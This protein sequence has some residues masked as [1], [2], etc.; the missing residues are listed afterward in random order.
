L[1]TSVGLLFDL[2]GVIID[3]VDSHYLNYVEILKAHG[4]V[5]SKDEFSILNGKNLNEIV[6][7][8]ASTHNLQD[9][10]N[11]IRSDFESKFKLSLGES[12]LIPGI[13]E[14][15]DF[16]KTSK[17]SLGVVS[18]SSKK[19]IDE[20]LK[21]H[22]ISHYFETIVSG[23]EVEQAKPN[24]AIYLLAKKRLNANLTF[25]VEDTSNGVISANQAGIVTI[26]YSPQATSNTIK[27]AFTISRIIN[28][29]EIVKSIGKKAFWIAYSPSIEVNLIDTSP[30]IMEGDNVSDAD[31][32][33][34]WNAEV[35]KNSNL[36]NEMVTLYTGHQKSE[37]G[38]LTIE[39]YETK[40]QNV[41][42]K[43]R[44]ITDSQ[45]FPLA[46][47][48]IVMDP[49]ENILIGK[50]SDRV[51]EYSEFYEIVPSGA[52]PAIYANGSK[53]IDQMKIELGE[54]SPISQNNIA[55]TLPLGL[56]FDSKNEVYDI[57]VKMY[58]NSK[59]SGPLPASKE[60][61]ELSFVELITAY[62]ML[63]KFPFVPVSE[64]ILKHLS[65]D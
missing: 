36:K 29:Q 7:Y 6:D 19:Q 50:R 15:L 14:T 51:S 32:N 60:Y 40:Y 48:G 46:V 4:I 1:S 42:A 33:K 55:S 58:L 5:G 47:S 44:K 63:E 30:K 31:A 11:E 17:I 3:S 38:N 43:L 24:P 52:L 34:L 37:A 12:K 65:T 9:I 18:S 41:F 21:K 39:C 56:I 25:A 64:A 13:L 61:S 27:P 57:I 8:I 28:I 20:T 53:F 59:I 16:L 35:L 49:S 62:D 2:D 45:I 54:E 23:E 26:H 22:R 10:K